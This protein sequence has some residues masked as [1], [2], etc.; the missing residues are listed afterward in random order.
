[1]ARSA[2]ARSIETAMRGIRLQTRARQNV[3]LAR[4][5]STTACSTRCVPFA[6]QYHT[7]RRFQ[8]PTT[9]PISSTRLSN[10]ARCAS[11]SAKAASDGNL[12]ELPLRAIHEEH[13]A[14]FV[15]F[16]GYNMPLQYRDQSHLESHHWTRHNAS[17]FDVSHMYASAVSHILPY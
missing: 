3:T 11:S 12:R 17:L 13:G 8:R 14:Q 10:V 16:G 4:V 9:P 15:P 7:L 5:L 2:A 6:Q 1:M